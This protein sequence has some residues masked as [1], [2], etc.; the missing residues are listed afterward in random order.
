MGNHKSKIAG[1]KGLRAMCWRYIVTVST[2]DWR[3]AWDTEPTVACTKRADAASA[4]RPV[5]PSALV[6][7]E[8]GAARVAPE[9]GAARPSGDLAAVDAAS[10]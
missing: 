10:D 2:T 4:F 3:E 7:R 9:V 1:N 6:V 5:S 8:A